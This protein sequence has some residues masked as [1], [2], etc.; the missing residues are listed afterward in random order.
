MALTNRAGA[1]SGKPGNISWCKDHQAI[2]MG[3]HAGCSGV[4]QDEGKEGHQ[5]AHNIYSNP[6]GVPSWTDTAG[7]QC[8]T[9]DVLQQKME[10][11]N[12]L[13]TL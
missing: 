11:S 13:K 10:L 12:V 5:A 7:R 8:E 4:L 3:H 1:A 6:S 9:N 2:V